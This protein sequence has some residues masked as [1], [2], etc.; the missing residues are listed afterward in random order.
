MKFPAL[1]EFLSKVGIFVP[2]STI[3]H[4]NGVLNYLYV[5]RWMHE[6]GLRIPLRVRGREALYKILAPT[7]TE[8]AT[9]LEFG[10]FDGTSIRRWA[11]LLGNPKTT[12]YGFDSFEGLPEDWGLVCDR[13][14]FDVEGRIPVIDDARVQFLKGWFQDTLPGFLQDFTP[15]DTLIVHLDADLYSSTI[16][17][18]RQ[19]LPLLKPATVLI[20][21]EFFD[22]EHEIKAF[23]EFLKDTGMCVECIA[24]TRALTQVA[25]RVVAAPASAD[26]SGQ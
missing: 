10:V 1:K 2:T 13:E 8:P 15:R 12:L 26:P 14:T 9:Y 17:V 5:G 3:H 4:L 23:A 7:I 18:L 11:R 16:Y 19:L 22:R 24:A 21:D 6:R 25:F 20:F